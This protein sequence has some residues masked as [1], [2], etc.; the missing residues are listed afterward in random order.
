MINPDT[1]KAKAFEGDDI[2]L[3]G[4]FSETTEAPH[5]VVVHCNEVAMD[6]IQRA[7]KKLQTIEGA[8]FLDFYPID[9]FDVSA[10]ED[11]GEN[12][13][14]GFG[15]NKINLGVVSVIVWKQTGTVEV[16]VWDKHTDTYL[17]LGFCRI[18]KETGECVG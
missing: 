3:G 8:R 15:D 7:F 2:I 5:R 18:D 10:F 9:Y 11:T 1:Y 16:K 14:E 12:Y 4:E 6:E 17:L 13:W